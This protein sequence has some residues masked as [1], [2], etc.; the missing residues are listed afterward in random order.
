MTQSFQLIQSFRLIQCFVVFD[1][2][3][4]KEKST[5]VVER[6]RRSIKRSSDVIFE[7][8]M[9]N[10]ISQEM[11]L[12]KTTN[13]AKF[14]AKLSQNLNQNGIRTAQADTLIVNTAIQLSET[15]SSDIYI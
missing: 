1:G 11:F 5:K 7:E 12:A 6:H 10:N 9:V 15:V 13:K 2:Y 14:I 8:H 4:N 3:A